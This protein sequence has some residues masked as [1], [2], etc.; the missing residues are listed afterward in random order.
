MKRIFLAAWAALFCV[1]A[2]CA[3]AQV[4]EPFPS[5]LITVVVPFPAGG[6][7]DLLA[8][9]VAEQIRPLLGQ[10]VIIENKPGASGNLGMEGVARSAPDGYTLINAP[11]LSF[12]VNHLL[13]P[14]LRFDPR[15][16][17][18]VSVLATYPT[19]IFAR[20]DLP[21]NSLADVIAYAK[22]NPGKL[23]Y[24]SQGRGQIG[25]LTME[26]LR[27][28]AG[29]DILHVPYRGSAP[30]INDLLA[31]QIDILADNMLA[32]M[33]HVRSGKLKLIAVGG[34]ERLKAFPNVATFAETLPEYYSD[35]WMAIAAPSGTPK[36]VTRKL[37]DAI[38]KALQ[39]PELRRRIEDL[40]A[41][42]FGS[43]P[44]QMAG[45]IR[46]SNARWAP[47]IEQA[48]IRSE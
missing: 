20:A 25:H 5:R 6:T 40:Q 22:A 31:G 45:L 29:L 48:N 7:A 26:A 9:L 43:T 36:D 11:Q 39:N 46:E 47:V 35:T 37:S 10:T 21:A 3:H 23:T 17:E 13:N 28:R 38:A 30:A 1:A 15:A 42:P 4:T 41:E 19:V 12:S 18:P 27:L 16:L 34:K 24:G 32:G 8:R 2:G 14:N 44:E 33:Q